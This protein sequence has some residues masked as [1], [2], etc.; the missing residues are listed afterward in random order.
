MRGESLESQA[1]KQR[2][3]RKTVCPYGVTPRPRIKKANQQHL[4]KHV[5]SHTSIRGEKFRAKNAQSTVLQTPSSARVRSRAILTQNA[6]DRARFASDEPAER[7][8]EVFSQ[9]GNARRSTPPI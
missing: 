7:K 3:Q 4:E 9:H 2:R 5:S 6:D 1:R 8:R